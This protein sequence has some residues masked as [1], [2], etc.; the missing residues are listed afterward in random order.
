ITN[1]NL[2]VRESAGIYIDDNPVPVRSFGDSS[3]SPLGTPFTV[4]SGIIE[5]NNG[6]YGW[7][8]N[9]SPKITVPDPAPFHLQAI[10]FEVESS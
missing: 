8:I 7:G 10:Q 9:V 1:M 4:K 5:N 2:R 6:G 3:N